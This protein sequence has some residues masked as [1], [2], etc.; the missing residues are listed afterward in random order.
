[1]RINKDEARK[2]GIQLLKYGVI[3][4]SNTLIT[5]IA[6]YVLNTLCGMPYGAA[7]VIGYVLGVLNSFYWNR[8]WVFKTKNDVKR[9]AFFFGVGFFLCLSLQLLVSWFLLEGLGWKH[10]SEISWLPMKKT[11]QNIVMIISM[12]IYT[13]ANYIY[14][15]TVTFKEKNKD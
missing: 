15:R 14:N 5:L 9:E 10:M 13:I 8:Q 6:F 11:G 3:G 1:M 7:N 4:M 2:T 12:A